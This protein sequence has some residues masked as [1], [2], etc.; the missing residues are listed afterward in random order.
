MWEGEQKRNREKMIKKRLMDLP[1]DSP[2]PETAPSQ[3][4]PGN[5]ETAVGPAACHTGRTGHTEQLCG[6]LAGDK[7][8]AAQ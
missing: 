2:L 8:T 5:K 7:G 6:A 3:R 1:R 4:W